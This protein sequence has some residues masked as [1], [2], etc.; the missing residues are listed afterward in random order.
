[1]RR[2][3][4]NLTAETEAMIFIRFLMFGTQVCGSAGKDFQV[5]NSFTWQQ[6][7]CTRYACASS[8]NKHMNW[9]LT[10]TA[11][12][13]TTINN[14]RKYI[15]TCVKCAASPLHIAVSSSIF[16]QLRGLKSCDPNCKPYSCQVPL[17][18]FVT[19]QR[20]KEP[21][22]SRIYISFCMSQTLLFYSIVRLPGREGFRPKSPCRKQE[23][24]SEASGDE[25][26]G[27][28]CYSRQGIYR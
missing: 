23:S 20:V 27:S 18:D 9:Q 26:P 8:S 14:W 1:M 28:W 25:K 11:R 15:C 24:G 4:R 21:S 16:L 7:Q 19:I 13:A 3:W 22:S 2:L 12:Y 6:A 17:C 5:Y 10:W